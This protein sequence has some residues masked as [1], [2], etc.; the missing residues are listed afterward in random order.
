[1]NDVDAAKLIR[2]LLNISRETPW[3]EFKCNYA[4]PERIGEYISALSNAAALHDRDEGYIVWGIDDAMRKP[5]GTT[6][7]PNT[8]KIGGGQPLLMHLAQNLVPAVQLD[9][10]EGTVDGHRVVAVRVPAAS[11]SPVA[12]KGERFIRIG[13]SKTALQGRPEERTLFAKLDKT[14]F[15]MRA[16]LSRL[17]EADVLPR[18][19]YPAYFDLLNVPLPENRA[20][21]FEQLAADRLIRSEPDGWV[22]TNLGALLFA[23]SLGRFDAL[24]RKVVRVV[25]YKNDDRSEI[26]KQ[27]ASDKG[28]A[29][30]F[31]GLMQWINDQVPQNVHIG[32]ALRTEIKMY[33]EVA[34]RELVAN[35]LIHQDVAISGTG[36]LVEIFPHR[37]EITNPGRP[38]IDPKRFLDLP[39]I[40]RNEK[41]ASLMRRMGMCEE[42]GSGID[43]VL[44]AIEIYQLPAP[45]FAV[46]DGNTRVTLFAH[47]SFSEMDKNERVRAA[48]QH[49]GL[50][51]VTQ[52]RMT[53]STLRDRFGLSSNEYTKASAVIRDALDAGVIVADNPENK[54]ARHAKYVPFWAARPASGTGATERP[55]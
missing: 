18:L 39:P 20:A 23:K 43:R 48:Y 54:A 9:P 5:V 47:R 26:A 3:L 4:H 16:A 30:G 25:V 35:A 13:E 50:M 14:P 37:I 33:P 52:K 49:A 12:Y 42:L 51:C 2:S 17:S 31:E 1:M 28:Y 6:F 34:V 22:I 36:P 38:L 11:A 10:L 46:T 40:S 24:A 32:E 29:A 44:T 8:A 19:D 7:D 45:D 21:I 55:T 53:N 15:E 27:Q 41:L